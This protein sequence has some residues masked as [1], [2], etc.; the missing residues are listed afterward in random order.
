MSWEYKTPIC[1]FVI[2]PYN[3]EYGLFVDSELLQTA[4]DPGAL[5][6]NVFTHTSEFYPWDASSFEASDSLCDWERISS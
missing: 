2:R 5:A 3:G 4:L 1:R 6:D